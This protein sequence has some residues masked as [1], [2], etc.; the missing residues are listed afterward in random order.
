M[1]K[2]KLAEAFAFNH[3]SV[4]IIYPT[5]LDGRIS[6]KEWVRMQFDASAEI[7]SGKMSPHKYYIVSRGDK[8]FPTADCVVRHYNK[9]KVSYLYLL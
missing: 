8:L 6:S 3:P 2:L 4:R 1:T 5:S 7:E 9:T